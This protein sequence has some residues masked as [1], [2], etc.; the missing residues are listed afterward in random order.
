MQSKPTIIGLLSKVDWKSFQ[1]YILNTEYHRAFNVLGSLWQPA[2]MVHNDCGGLLPPIERDALAFL[3]VQKAFISFKSELYDTTAEELD[4]AVKL[5]GWSSMEGVWSSMAE[6][7]ICDSLARA[8]FSP[9]IIESDL[10]LWNVPFPLFWLIVSLGCELGEV[11]YRIDCL[12]KCFNLFSG[13]SKSA[14]FQKS[15]FK[16]LWNDSNISMA[17]ECSLFRC[18]DLLLQL[19]MPQVGL[20]LLGEFSASYTVV[21]PSVELLKVK[22]SLEAGKHEEAVSIMHKIEPVDPLCGQVAKAYVCQSVKRGDSGMT[23]RAVAAKLKGTEADPSI[24]FVRHCIKNNE[25][26]SLIHEGKFVSAFV[27]IYESL[28]TFLPVGVTGDLNN[29]NM[30][31]DV[32]RV[33]LD[34]SN[35]GRVVPLPL[36]F[37][38]AKLLNEFLPLAQSRNMT[39]RELALAR[40]MELP[41]V[42]RDIF[43]VHEH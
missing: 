5:Y 19:S 2:W 20:K 14:A 40:R 31:P 28:S 3:V 7:C 30:C 17:Q 27:A 4:L 42:F 29:P 9:F 6:F 24:D 8:L 11:T 34:T 32:E 10:Q 22:L 41:S 33:S 26:V 1:N 37:Q 12:L 36:L 15:K 21:R 35:P 18:I 39:I 23:F 13:I 16:I 38:N 25:A 43:G